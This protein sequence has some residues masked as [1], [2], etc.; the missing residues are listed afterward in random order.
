MIKEITTYIESETDLVIGSDLFAGFI[1]ASV[2]GDA[3]VVIETGGVPTPFLPDALAKSIQ[4]LSR[5]KDYHTAMDN[6]IIVYNLLNGKAGI[7][8]TNYRINSI[9]A[10]SS[11]QSLGQDEKSLFNIS[12]NFVLRV[13]DK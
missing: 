5:S 6:A 4:V 13:M 1:P 3:V 8:L 10:I 12:T 7:D 9:V 2:L 11:P